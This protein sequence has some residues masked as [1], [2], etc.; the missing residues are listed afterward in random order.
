MRRCSPSTGDSLRR[1]V[2]RRR[3]NASRH[4]R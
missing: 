2:T 1:P 3:S 4:D